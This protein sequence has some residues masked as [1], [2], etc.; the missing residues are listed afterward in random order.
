MIYLFWAT[1]LFTI[2]TLLTAAAS[3]RADSTLVALIMQPFTIIAPL[4]AL[5]PAIAKKS[6]TIGKPALIMTIAAGLCI[7][8]FAMTI[9]KSY[10]VNKVGIVT[11]VIYGG[12]ILLSTIFSYFLFKESLKGFELVG[13]ILVFVGISFIIY[14]R[15]VA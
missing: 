14:A 3:R 6:I 10:T 12:V 9:N 1:L 8:L 5:A 11:P 7:G 15:A 4:L 2:A 13:L